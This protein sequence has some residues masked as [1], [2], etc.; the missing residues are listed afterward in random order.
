MEGKYLTK[1]GD[2]GVPLLPRSLREAWA[3]DRIPNWV[4]QEC[5]LPEG[6]KL[7]A[8]GAEIWKQLSAMTERLERYL[9]ALVETRIEDISSLSALGRPWPHN[10]D[11]TAVP[12]R[13]RTRNCLKRAGLLTDKGQLSHITFGEL[14]ALP[15]MGIVSLLDF[16]TTAEA[17][18]ECLE[19]LVPQKGDAMTNLM[20]SVIDVP[21]T[22]L[23]TAEDPRFTSYFPGR[24]GSLTQ[25]LEA[26]L[27]TGSTAGIDAA[28][29]GDSVEQLNLFLED[30]LR[31]I[32]TRVRE[33]E[34]MPLNVAL[35]DYLVALSHAKDR[36]LEALLA[37]FGWN[38]APPVT[39]RESAVMMDVSFERVRQIQE[40]LIR[41]RPS[42][43][44][45][46]PTLERALETLAN[47]APLDVDK[48]SE[49]LKQRSI[50]TIPFHPESVL[51]AAEFCGHAATFKLDTGRQGAYIITNSTLAYASRVKLIA[52]RL[53]SASGV[54][55]ITEIAAAAANKELSVTTE[56]VREALRQY[57]SAQFLDDN[58]V[59]FWMPDGKPNRNRL[60]NVT[61][62]ILS[63]A[64]PLDPS[65][66]REGISRYYR[67]RLPSQSSQTLIVPPRSVL[68]AFY[69]ANP[70]F[71]VEEDGQISPIVPLDYRKELG[72]TEQVFVEVLRSTPTG[73]LDR[74]G[75]F[76]AC[77]ERGVN[78][79]TLNSF[80]SSSPIIQQVDTGIWS[81]RG[82][83]V[84]PVAV[85]LMREAL[86]MRPREQRIND[87]GWTPRGALW[88]A[89]RL[90]NTITNFSLKIPSAIA[91]Y[92]TGSRFP[93][94]SEDG[95]DSGIV[96]VDDK[97]MSWG[98][99][100][101]LSRRGADEDDIL[102]VEFDLVHEQVT[103]KLEAE[104]FLD[105][106]THL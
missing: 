22:E 21:W 92:V 30:N 93:V 11:P 2:P 77:E 86:A 51:T 72:A 23:I 49:L 5:K 69:A 35:R 95:S 54:S 59:W 46:L 79:N 31:A 84:D 3:E 104:D 91:Q 68:T 98:Y 55:N 34:Q 45:F 65:T 60:H 57:T 103:L 24:H 62:R 66:I 106:S 13:T 53:A 63:V 83:R 61:R 58:A 90:P 89:I 12:W 32:L 17:A 96:V 7:G 40:S 15:G 78:M 6:T 9:L 88:I 29:G 80:L 67:H 100:P 71:V 99:T 14:M 47:S 38:G 101:F 105:E 20:L 42:H 75:F 76:K 26:I 87:Y 8:F 74:Q 52:G 33:I 102:L 81:L 28:L 94:R 50:T 37:R 85:A 56:Q 25:Q 64:S 10:L 82:V 73:I 43:P 1:W 19:Q 41:K 16:A 39:L 4:A 70:S 44:V 48:A 27:T 97:A 18:M 36:R